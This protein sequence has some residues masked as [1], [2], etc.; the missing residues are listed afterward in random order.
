MKYNQQKMSKNY[1]I[2]KIKIQPKYNLSLIS[3]PSIVPSLFMSGKWLLNAGFE[4]GDMAV[5]TAKKNYLLIRKHK[6]Q[7]EN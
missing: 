7:R 4:V 5:I 1:G 2:R 6:E 3:P